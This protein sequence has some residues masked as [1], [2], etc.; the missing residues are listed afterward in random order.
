MREAGKEPKKTE[1][2]RP[3]RRERG[4]EGQGE[5]REEP[6][7]GAAPPKTGGGWVG[8]GAWEEDSGGCH[9]SLRGGVE[10]S[11]RRKEVEKEKGR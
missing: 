8:V 4:G 2:E 6:E 9:R 10:R 1:E 3:E 11:G 5:S 7:E